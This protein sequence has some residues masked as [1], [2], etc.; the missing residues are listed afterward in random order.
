MGLSDFLSN[1]LKG[2]SSGKDEWQKCPSCGEQVN[3]SMERC[4]KCGVH[5]SSMFRR[6]CPKCH[7]LNELNIKKC[8]KCSYDFEA[9]YI[10]YK[11]TFFQCPICAFQSEAYL[12]SCPV[13]NT[14][15]I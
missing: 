12:T 15:F 2:G 10:R 1:M 13:C 4:P 9:E 3:L 7:A 8:A 5:I 6:K 14:R 11:K